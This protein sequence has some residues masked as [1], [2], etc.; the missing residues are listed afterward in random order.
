MAQPGW[1]RIANELIALFAQPALGTEHHF[2]AVRFD[3]GSQRLAEH[4][5]G[6]AEAVPLCGVEEVDAQL[7][8]P[9]QR[10]SAFVD[11]DRSPLAAK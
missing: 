5:L 11:V 8:G 4:L 1:T 9:A 6:C 3:L 10:C 7:E 2:V